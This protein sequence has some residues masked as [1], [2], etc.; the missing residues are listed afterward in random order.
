MV[1]RSN[2]AI[3]KN[4][5][6]KAIEK[7]V[8]E[9]ECVYHLVRYDKYKQ[10][11]QGAGL[12]SESYSDYFILCHANSYYHAGWLVCPYYRNG[13]CSATKG[14]L[15]FNPSR[16]GTR[17]Y[18]NHMNEHK[19]NTNSVVPFSRDL[20]AVCQTSIIEAAVRAVVLDLRPLSFAENNKGLA[21]FATAVFKSGQT[22]PPTVCINMKSI[23]PS[24]SAVT[25]SLHLQANLMRAKL[26]DKIKSVQNPMCGAAS[27][28]G[29]S[30][31][32]QRK[33]YYDF[34]LYFMDII[35]PKN[36]REEVSFGIKNT[37]ILLV[38]GP[39]SATAV[40]IRNTLDV[41][42]KKYYGIGIDTIQE[43]FTMVT[44]G[45]AVMASMAGSSV[46]RAI[47][48]LDQTW[49]RC[50]VHAFNNV[51]KDTMKIC[52]T[53]QYLKK[54]SEDFK[55]MKKVV[56]DS[57]QSHWNSWLPNG[58]HLIQEVE[59]RFGTHLQVAERFLKSADKVYSLLVTH[60]KRSVL[61]TFTSI[62]T[63][64]GMDGIS[65]SFPNIEAIVDTFSIL[66]EAIVRFE[67][68][69]NP[70]IHK[71]LPNFLDIRHRLTHIIN[72]GAISRTNL[73][74][75][76]QPSFMVKSLSAVIL[77][78]VDKIE[79]HDLWIVA[80]FLHPLMR[81]LLFIRPIETRVEYKRRAEN[82]ARALARINGTDSAPISSVN[83]LNNTSPLIVGAKRKFSMALFADPKKNVPDNADE[84]TKYCILDVAS[85]PFNRESAMQDDYFAVKFWY[86]RK[87]SFPKLYAVAMRV[88]ATPVSSCGSE[89]VFST[90][91]K[92][93]SK[94]RT[95]L[96]PRT[97][98]DIIVM[99]FLLSE[100]E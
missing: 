32:L 16:G 87:R 47:H 31:K 91:N 49:M 59:T 22:V 35:K 73:Q 1:I 76:F 85:L 70:T 89:R 69:Q 2:S 4:S 39:D 83:F 30:L 98:Q 58:Y 29:V 13:F 14:L 9:E 95:S 21:E 34:T 50:I 72:N 7:I 99:R 48:P 55:A 3:D 60:K 57:K 26:A 64:T 62:Y 18:K 65:K 90:L 94:D 79:I 52:E 12:K 75:E 68:T 20:S 61:E 23:L 71:I 10:S 88:Y 40:N 51:M 82:M 43:T 41:N 100:M 63:E 28:D 44:D 80:C 74:H 86:D 53:D 56:T 97:I 67:G 54:L 17:K 11:H 25:Q 36:L 42:L 46:S 19:D 96:T 45:A 27:C 33:H 6:E 92:L 78:E 84:V 93:V 77:Q 15:E 24:K 37:T 8:K 38:E 81:D 5:A 66:N